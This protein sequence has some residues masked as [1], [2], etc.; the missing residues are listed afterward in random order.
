MVD[1]FCVF[2]PRNLTFQMVD[3]TNRTYGQTAHDE[4]DAQAT[5]TSA[6]A[7]NASQSSAQDDANAQNATE[8]KKER[9]L[10]EESLNDPR[11][12]TIVVNNI[13]IIIGK[14]YYYQGPSCKRGFHD[15]FDPHAVTI[16]S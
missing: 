6:Q 4:I 13:T 10:L 11:A 8:G 9:D 12:V 14:I 1:D 2:Y 15:S 3:V 5:D 7:D 16:R